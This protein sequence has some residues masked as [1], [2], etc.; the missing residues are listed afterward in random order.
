MVRAAGPGHF[1]D[2]DM[3]SA[4]LFAC[5]IATASQPA[6]QPIVAIKRIEN[7]SD[8]SFLFPQLVV[9]N[10]GLSMSEQQSQFSLW[11]IFSAPLFISADLRTIKPDSRDLLLNND[12][13]AVNQDP[14]GR[15]GWCA[16]ENSFTRVWV[17][18]LLPSKDQSSF[19]LNEPPPPGSSDR[20]AVVLQNFRSIFNAKNITFDPKHHI[21]TTALSFDWQF[22]SVRDL[23]HRHDLGVFEGTYSTLVDES[24]VV[25]LLV[26]REKHFDPPAIIA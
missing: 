7:E 24:S 4:V 12:I 25:M 22:F 6:N 1:N 5:W 2:P 11:A 15:Q 23:I 17:R 14:L 16:E 20:W 26:T 13:I 10:P 21:S 8:V 19:G 18:E 9:G 3:V